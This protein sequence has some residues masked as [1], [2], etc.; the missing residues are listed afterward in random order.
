VIC[1]AIA[2]DVH[3]IAHQAKADKSGFINHYHQDHRSNLIPLCKAHHREIHDGAIK[4]KGFVMTSKGLELDFEEQLHQEV[5]VE[6]EPEI[7]IVEEKEDEKA[8]L[9][10][11]DF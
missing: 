4:V 6:T 8:S 1:G 10:W 5:V 3:H 11:D 2:E 9:G 7:K